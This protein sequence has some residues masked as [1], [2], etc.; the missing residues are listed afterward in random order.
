MAIMLNFLY[1]SVVCI[2]MGT[3]FKQGFT[4]L[5]LGAIV[6][7]IAGSYTHLDVYKRQGYTYI[8]RLMGDKASFMYIGMF[9]LSQV[10]IATFARCV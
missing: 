9:V 4:K 7:S 8:K 5:Q 3:V 10:L 1:P 2:V 6:C